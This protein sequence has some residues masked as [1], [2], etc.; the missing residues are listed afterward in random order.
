MAPTV[1]GNLLVGPDAEDIDDKDNVSTT[2]ERLNFVREKAVKSIDKIEFRDSIRNFAGL[3]AESSRGDFIIEESSVDNFFDVA[4]IKSPGLSAAPAIGLDLARMVVEKLGNVEKKRNFVDKRKQIVFMELNP[5][6][7]TKLIRE[8][9]EYGRVI[10][11]CEN[12]TEGEIIDAIRRPLG[13]TTIDGIK[14]RCRPGMGRCQGG[15]CGP[16]VQ[17]ILARE[18]KVKLEEI[19]LDKK[20]SY[21]LTGETK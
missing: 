14:K 21:I 16:R 15:F 17:E 2:R 4:G 3:R 20:N 19:V 5:R 6:E 1:H 9:P 18:L 7:K 12:I 13:A 10:C 8:K 11:R